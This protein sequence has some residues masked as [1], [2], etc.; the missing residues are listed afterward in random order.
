MWILIVIVIILIASYAYITYNNLTYL[1]KKT[2]KEFLELDVFFKRRISLLPNLINIFNSYNLEKE[3]L[4]RISFL[5]KDDYEKQTVKDKINLNIELNNLLN[6]LWEIAD[7]NIILKQNPV[8]LN[9]IKQFDL[10][11]QEIVANKKY[12]NEIINKYNKKVNHFPSNIIAK[13][14]KLK[15]KYPYDIDETKRRIIKFD[16]NNREVIK[17]EDKAKKEDEF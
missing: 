8:F 16:T 17:L 10:A 3:T 7:A 4:N 13:L 12:Y 11:E 9:V 6:R 5:I 14:L 1:N 15:P 2:D